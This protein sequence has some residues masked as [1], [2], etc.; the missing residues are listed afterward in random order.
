MF[1]LTT[2][3]LCLC[4]WLN[5]EN[6]LTCFAAVY[7]KVVFLSQQR[8]GQPCATTDHF[9]GIRCQFGWGGGG[10]AVGAA[11]FRGLGNCF[12]QDRGGLMEAVSSWQSGACGIERD[13]ESNRKLS[14]DIRAPSRHYITH[15]VLTKI[16]E[17]RRCCCLSGEFPYTVKYKKKTGAW[18]QT[19]TY[20]IPS[21]NKVNSQDSWEMF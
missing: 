16:W 4:F 18:A 21:S 19:G 11:H 6:Y 7:C 15:S 20:F 14:N 2:N 12:N 9:A 3:K 17:K 10:G 5:V 1:L 13:K 8:L